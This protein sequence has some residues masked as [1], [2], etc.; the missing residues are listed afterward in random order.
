MKKIKRNVSQ[1]T[2]GKWIANANNQ[3]E[4][5]AKQGDN[6]DPTDPF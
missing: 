4:E 5:N 6:P 2:E 1:N 3:A